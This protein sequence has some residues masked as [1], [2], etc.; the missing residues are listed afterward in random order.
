MKLVVKS[1]GKIQEFSPDKLE[2]SLIITFNMLKTPE[3]QSERY[4]KKALSEF[5]NW[6]EDKPEITSADIRRKISEI[7]QNIDPSAAYIFENFKGIM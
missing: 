5:E 6:Q 2:K 7:L 4:I 3:G 1:D